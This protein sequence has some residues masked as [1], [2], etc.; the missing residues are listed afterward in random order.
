MQYFVSRLVDESGSSSGWFGL[1]DANKKGIFAWTDKNC[2]S[3]YHNWP[4]TEPNPGTLEDCVVGGAWADVRCDRQEQC[5]CQKPHPTEITPRGSCF[6]ARDPGDDFRACFPWKCGGLYK[7]GDSSCWDDKL[8]NAQEELLTYEYMLSTEPKT[9]D[10]HEV[11]AQRWGGHVASIHTENENHLMRTHTYA[12]KDYFSPSDGMTQNECKN[13]C[14]AHDA[15]QPCI[16]N[17]AQQ[18]FLASKFPGFWLGLTDQRW[19]GNFQWT[20]IVCGSTYRNWSPGEPNNGHGSQD[21]AYSWVTKDGKWDDGSCLAKK[22]CVCE[23]EA[24][25]PDGNLLGA[26]RSVDSGTVTYAWTDGTDFGFGENKLTLGE[27]NMY[28]NGD[29]FFGSGQAMTFQDCEIY[30][31][32]RGASTPCIADASL[33]SFVSHRFSNYWLG[34]RDIDNIGWFKWADPE[35]SSTFRRWNL[36]EPTSAIFRTWGMFRNFRGLHCAEVDGS[37]GWSDTACNKLKTCVCQATRDGMSDDESKSNVRLSPIDD[38]WED[39]PESYRACAPYKRRKQ[40]L[41]ISL[42][43]KSKF[44]ALLV[45]AVGTD[46]R[47]DGSLG[48]S[49]SKNFDHVPGFYY[50]SGESMANLHLAGTQTVVYMVK[51]FYDFQFSGAPQ[52]SGLEL[53]FEPA[54]NGCSTKM[55]FM[56]AAHSLGE[57]PTKVSFSDLRTNERFPSNEL[58][59]FLQFCGDVSGTSVFSGL[60]I[61]YAGCPENS[62]LFIDGHTLEPGCRCVAGYRSSKYDREDVKIDDA[63]TPVA[64]LQVKTGATWLEANVTNID[65]TRY[66]NAYGFNVELYKLVRSSRSTVYPGHGEKI[67]KEQA[68]LEAQGLQPGRWYSLHMVPINAAEEVLKMEEGKIQNSILTHCSCSNT[69]GAGDNTGTPLSLNITQ[70][71]GF[72]LFSFRDDSVCEDSYAFTREPVLRS[73]ETEMAKESFTPNYYFHSRLACARNPVSPGRQASD[74]LRVSRLKV[75]DEYSYCV[76]ATA[77]DYMQHP[78]GPEELMLASSQENCQTHKIRWESSIKGKVTMP[79]NAGSLPVEEVE[80]SWALLDRSLENTIVS[81]QAMT[82]AA[83]K[84]DIV[85]NEDLLFENYVDYPV[86]VKVSKKTPSGNMTINHTFECNEGTLNCTESGTT[87]YLSHLQFD[88]PLHIVGTTSVLFTGKV[89]VG[90]TDDPDLSGDGCPIIGAEVCLID[91]NAHGDEIA[92]MCTDTDAFGTYQLGA[93]IGLHVAVEVRYH[94]H[95][96]R[97]LD[98]DKID[99]YDNGI[100]IKADGVYERNDFKDVTTTD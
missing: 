22:P 86:Q 38:A 7:D 47:F 31:D 29:T 40:M 78:K 100:I 4:K 14:L 98:D 79:R 44:T 96:F 43:E 11:E 75:G 33:N 25:C 70:K 35:C 67:K 91:K 92:E 59:I 99:S 72:I 93:V 17:G 41:Q 54:G 13:Y 74:N 18:S 27:Q 71:E 81:G 42:Q 52:I 73:S 64:E 36:N 84:F 30:C 66:N 89:V 58:L 48:D 2:L 94:Q 34:L 20:N 55:S 85:F 39:V 45:P 50:V 32:A 87:V 46:G 15:Q 24:L 77:K 10:E 80:V 5:I 57:E 19:E 63:C 83:G 12:G 68:I 61:K 28:S 6:D 69:D 16:L 21:C 8:A 1:K 3:E 90:D 88:E 62:H 56:G 82:S 53:D 49:R 9:V 60:T 95:E 51:H 26:K 23:I 65:M 76:R 37:G 97:P